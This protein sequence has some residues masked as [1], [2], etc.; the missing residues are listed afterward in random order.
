MA[1]EQTT[2]PSRWRQRLELSATLLTI[3]AGLV[4]VTV[5]GGGL[6]RTA[7][8]PTR[9]RSTVPLPSKPLSLAGA[10]LR[11]DRNAPIAILE[12]SDFQC[13]YCARFAQNTLEEVEKQYI[14]S[15]QVLFAFREFPI[16]RL[17][18][19]ARRAAEA[20]VCAG[21]QGKFVEAHNLLFDNQ[22]RLLE[23]IGSIAIRARLDSV[24]FASCLARVG[25]RVTAD[26]ES[27]KALQIKGTPTF[28]VGRNVAGELH[29]RQ[30]FSGSIDLPVFAE[31]IEAAKKQ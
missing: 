1:T 21:D 18:P 22:D 14:Q 2:S 31:A 30:V 8:D 24:A 5:M 9:G 25:P 29:V 27:A 3:I 7:K 6:L 4:I 19:N 16:E 28:F 10:A 23:A 17:H 26:I 15:G 13:P 11:G 12:Y 20:A